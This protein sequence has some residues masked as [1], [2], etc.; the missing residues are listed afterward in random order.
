MT[1]EQY[2]KPSTHS[3]STGTLSCNTELNQN[4]RFTADKTELHFNQSKRNIIRAY[5]SSWSETMIQIGVPAR[6]TDNTY[7]IGESSDASI[8]FYWNGVAYIGRS[9]ALTVHYDIDTE[10]MWGTFYFTALNN[11]YNDFTNGLFDIQGLTI[12]K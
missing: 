8:Y 5:Q 9:G 10:R 4:R 11:Q 1:I 3:N 2:I 12:I 6:F 7:E